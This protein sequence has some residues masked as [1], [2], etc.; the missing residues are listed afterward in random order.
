MDRHFATLLIASSLCFPLG[1]CMA[2][3][4][5]DDGT[6]GTDPTDSS[7]ALV[8]S[9]G[10][11][12]T[13]RRGESLA[14]R[15]G[16]LAQLSAEAMYRFEVLGSGGALLSDGDV[17]T[18]NRG[19]VFFAT[20][21]HDVGEDDRVAPG[22]RLSV[23]LRDEI[24]EIAA[25]GI[26]DVGGVPSLQQP[27][28]N[29]EEPAPPHIF[30]ANAAGEPTNAFAVGGDFAGEQRG[31]VH[32][33]GDGF[34]ENVAGRD[35]DVYVA[36]DRDEWRGSAIPR[37]GDASWIAG[38]IAVHVGADGTVAPTALFEPSLAQ[39]G[40][41]DILV[42]VDRDGMFE[43][44]F[45][46]K[47]G[48]DGIGRVGFTVQYSQAWLAARESSHIL[49]NIAYDN[50]S[51]DA[52]EWRNDFASSEPV[53]M[54]LN[55][56]VMHTYHFNVTKWIVRHQD[57]DAFWNNPAMAESDGGV[58]FAHFA[59]SSMDQPT[60]TGCTNSAPTCFGIVPLGD[61]V[62]Q[63]RFD[64]V[65]DRNGDGRYMPGEDLLDIIGGGTAGE[66]MTVEQF[67][68]LSAA[69]QAGFVVTV[70]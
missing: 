5:D 45:D 68:A 9:T 27:G 24:G 43:W 59:L 12:G 64:V 50:H 51:R 58:N 36:R 23:N 65:F 66:L 67:R 63:E 60:E 32:L 37:E 19:Q 18:D 1:G 29:V 20:V 17:R 22:D 53:F 48:A 47:D 40:I 49:V 69:Q 39:T 14:L 38:P 46:S 11:E 2:S 10:E 21:M 15:I 55:P 62:M 6:D 8:A 41:Y 25:R 56:P 28:F 54:Y 26:I 52:G 44:S 61:G 13:L 57:F 4:G 35:I 30:A 42:D 31:P 33:A 7:F 34:P 3:L 70:R 16:E